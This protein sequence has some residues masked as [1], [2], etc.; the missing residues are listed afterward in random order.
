MNEYKI[1]AEFEKWKK[2]H[3]YV[4]LEKQGH[5]FSRFEME[6]IFLLLN[7]LLLKNRANIEDC[8]KEYGIQR[9]MA[10]QC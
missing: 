3:A 8:V 10:H 1:V 5:A 4:N 2:L 6:E 7:K 9:V